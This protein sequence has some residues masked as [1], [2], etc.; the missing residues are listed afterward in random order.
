MIQNNTCYSFPRDENVKAQRCTA[1]SIPTSAAIYHS[2]VCS[3]H[4]YQNDFSNPLEPGRLTRLKKNA[5][6][7]KGII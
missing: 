1:L 4:F 7:H 3:D 2:R 6:P 5:V